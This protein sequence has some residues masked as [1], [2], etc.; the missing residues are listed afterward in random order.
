[1][2]KI[3]FNN[4]TIDH[5]DRCRTH[6]LQDEFGGKMVVLKIPVPNEPKPANCE[7]LAIVMTVEEAIQLAASLHQTIDEVLDDEHAVDPAHEVTR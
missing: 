1:M 2:I 3:E 6:S 4:E 5:R 7:R